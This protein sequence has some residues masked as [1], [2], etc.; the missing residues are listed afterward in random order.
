[1]TNK[2][3]L[4]DILATYECRANEYGCEEEI[5]RLRVDDTPYNILTEDVWNVQEI[6]RTFKAVEIIKPM[7]YVKKGTKKDHIML[8]ENRNPSKEETEM[9][10]K[11]LM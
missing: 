10:K 3:L 5:T 8:Y 4:H 2:E 9:I 11:W 7:I 1:M 6:I